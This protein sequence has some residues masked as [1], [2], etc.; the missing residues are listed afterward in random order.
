MESPAPSPSPASRR[1]TLPS[2]RTV[3]VMLF[4]TSPPPAG[5]L[6]VCP[7]CRSEL[8]HPV[9]WSDVGEGRWRVLLRCPNCERREEGI[10]GPETLERLD[11]AL[12]EATRAMVEDLRQLVR[13]NIEDDLDRFASALR[14]GHI[15]PMDF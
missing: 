12:D 8:V 1:V 3:D 15:W 9:D 4:G 14:Q 13:A 5:E 2:G 6:N 10:F 7:A 11:T